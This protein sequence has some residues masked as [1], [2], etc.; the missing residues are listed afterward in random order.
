M[1]TRATCLP[2]MGRLPV[3][4]LAAGLVTL[5]LAGCMDGSTSSGG[6]GTVGGAALGAGLGRLAF[7]DDTAG[8][9]IGGAVG[10]LAGNMTVD[11]R[12]EERRRQEAVERQRTQQQ[13]QIDFER[14][15]ALQQEQTRV[16]IE[17]QREFREWQRQRTGS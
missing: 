1:T 12:A 14:Q 13:L 9:L 2:L 4:A 10:G 16:E 8:M 15:R 3:M 11:R 17:E 6:A 7:S 5:T